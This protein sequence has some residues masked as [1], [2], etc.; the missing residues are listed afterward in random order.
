[1]K[2]K[3]NHILLLGLFILPAL[4]QADGGRNWIKMRDQIRV[5]RMEL[6]RQGAYDFVTNATTPR[7]APLMHSQCWVDWLP[8]EESERRAYEQEKRDFG[9]EF[10]RQIEKVALPEERFNVNATDA[11][12]AHAKRMLAIAGWL[13]TQPGYGNYILK[14]WAEFI[15]ESAMGRMA[16]QS[17]CSTNRVVAL[18]A[19]IDPPAKD[20][21]YRMAILDEEA[22]HRFVRPA[23]N[24]DAIDTLGRQWH[25]HYL[26]ARRHYGKDYA[27]S[28]LGNGFGAVKD[29]SP[30]YAFYCEDSNRKYN[31]IRAR[32]NMKKHYEV[33]VIGMSD[34]LLDAVKRILV[35]R[36]R[37]NV[38]PPPPKETLSNGDSN[39]EYLSR[40]RCM[41]RP[42]EKEFGMVAVGQIIINFYYGGGF[43][44]NTWQLALER[45]GVYGPTDVP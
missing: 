36:S 6:S 23:A 13:K 26:A 2:F 10:V 29:G 16:V 42:Y 35:F 5:L 15:A 31:T 9:L 19:K 18:L 43:D 24:E 4:C 11:H 28:V 32:W 38:I 37:I 44:Y 20:L 33:C 25:R 12:E 30:E 21:D 8:K 27:H 14:S 34:T 1:M 45:K 22:P 41:W 40:L 17:R 39:W 7:V 3:I